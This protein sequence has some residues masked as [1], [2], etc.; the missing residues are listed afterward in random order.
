[1]MLGSLRYDKVIVLCI[2]LCLVASCS[3]VD[4][5]IKTK[6]PVQTRPQTANDYQ[7]I[8]HDW[9]VKHAKNPKNQEI[10]KNYAKAVEEMKSA[11]DKAYEKDNYAFS[12]KIYGILHKN[13]PGFKRFAKWLSFNRQELN[14]RLSNCKTALYQN[15]FEQYRNNHLDEAIQSWQG[16]LSLDPH[17]EDIRKAVNTAILQ[18][19]NLQ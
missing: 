14:D 15:G 1:M 9:K 7:G 4:T 3:T 18:R 2:L 11:A 12:G 5:A 16:L 13:Y 10:M 19:K 8:L 17:N 6:D